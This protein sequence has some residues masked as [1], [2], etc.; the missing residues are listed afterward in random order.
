MACPDWKECDFSIH[1]ACKKEQ[2]CQNPTYWA[3]YWRH[4]NQ[5]NPDI[6]TCC[7]CKCPILYTSKLTK[8]HLIPRS[9]GGNNKPANIRDCCDS[10][11]QDRQNRSYAEWIRRLEER[12]YFLKHPES[13]KVTE[14]R[15]A[16][17]KEWRLYVLAAGYRLYK[18]E[19]DF[20]KY[21]HFEQ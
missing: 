11:N 16:S 17:A 2:L 3:E 4:K 13:L 12:T 20:R 14:A 15:L 18:S 1:N 6:V 10:C 19:G 5:P 21:G 8:E 7:Y 9:R